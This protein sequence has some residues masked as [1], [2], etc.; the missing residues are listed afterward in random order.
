MQKVQKTC[1]P[2]FKREAVWLGPGNGSQ[3]AGKRHR[4]QV[5]LHQIV[6]LLVRS[7]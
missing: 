7:L 1:T 5:G 3:S 6:K 2:E 4:G